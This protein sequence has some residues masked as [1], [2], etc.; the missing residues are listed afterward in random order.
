MTSPIKVINIFKFE[1]FTIGTAQ[2]RAT[3]HLFP[4]SDF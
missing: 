3:D 2:H 1:I 4:S